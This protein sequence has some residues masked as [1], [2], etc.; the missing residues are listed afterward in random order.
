MAYMSIRGFNVVEIR[1]KGMRLSCESI[2]LFAVAALC[3]VK[4]SQEDP[5]QSPSRPF[6]STMKSKARSVAAD[7]VIETR[8]FASQYRASCLS[9]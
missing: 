7:I 4:V 6:V 8:A 2:I 1:V 9:H 5:M 3:V